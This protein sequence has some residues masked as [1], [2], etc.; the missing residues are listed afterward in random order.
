MIIFAESFLY[1]R[2]VGKRLFLHGESEFFFKS[3]YRFVMNMKPVIVLCL[4][5]A[6]A[7]VSCKKELNES[8][9]PMEQ[10]STLQEYKPT[11]DDLISFM[12]EEGYEESTDE[13][14]DSEIMSNISPGFKKWMVLK[15]MDDYSVVVLYEDSCSYSRAAGE[16][17]K[18]YTP[19]YDEDDKTK[20]IR[21]ECLGEGNTCHVECYVIGPGFIR[22][23]IFVCEQ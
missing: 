15:K 14:T 16:C 6:I 11:F 13:S 18:I 17:N 7:L 4:F 5:V 21:Y 19:I 12:L 9:Y 20:I 23:T 2:N 10:R 22:C 3:L 1:I 8:M